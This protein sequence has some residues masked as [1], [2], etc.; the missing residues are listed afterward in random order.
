MTK[1]VSRYV[2]AHQGRNEGNLVVL[3]CA[4]WHFRLMYEL[5]KLELSKHSTEFY[6]LYFMKIRLNLEF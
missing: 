1:V 2:K 5:G 6:L 3:S 4:V